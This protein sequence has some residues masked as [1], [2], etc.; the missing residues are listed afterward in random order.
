MG[1]TLKG[2]HAIDFAIY[3]TGWY[4]VRN[5]NSKEGYHWQDCPEGWTKHDGSIEKLTSE[6]LY[7]KFLKIEK[8]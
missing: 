8:T 7:K 3:C 4:Y 2:Q 6:Q 1:I 5:D